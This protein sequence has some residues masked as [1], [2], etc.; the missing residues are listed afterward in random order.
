MEQR[1]QHLIHGLSLP[2]RMSLQPHTPV[3]SKLTILTTA[4][5]TTSPRPLSHPAAVVAATSP[6]GPAQL[7]ALSSDFSSWAVPLSSGS[8]AVASESNPDEEVRYLG[9]RVSG[10][11]SATQALLR[12]QVPRTQTCPPP[13]RADSR[14]KARLHRLNSRS[15]HLRLRLRWQGI[16]STK[17]MVS[18]MIHCDCD[19]LTK[20]RPQR[21]SDCGRRT[22]N[23]VQRRKPAGLV[24]DDERCYELQLS[25]IAGSSAGERRRRSDAAIPYPQRVELVERTVIHAN[26]R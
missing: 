25:R 11:G 8:S 16:R 13:Y 5:T 23:L 1:K 10:I 12:R 21:S 14:M 3:R 18:T 2:W 9:A 15:L 26:N 22:P 24:T 20:N 6:A 7:S 4:R 17:C 19:I